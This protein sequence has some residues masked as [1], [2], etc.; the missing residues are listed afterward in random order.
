MKILTSRAIA[1]QCLIQAG[2][3]ATSQGGLFD[4]YETVD[5]ASIG[6]TL[7]EN[8]DQF[9]AGALQA[10]SKS[11]QTKLILWMAA[12][13]GGGMLAGKVVGKINIPKLGFGAPMT[14]PSTPSQPSVSASASASCAPSGKPD[15]NSPLCTDSDCQ[16]TN[17]KTCRVSPNQNCACLIMATA[18]DQW[19]DQTYMNLQQQ[20]IG[21]IDA[22]VFL[23]SGFS[24]STSMSM[25]SATSMP[26]TSGASRRTNT[27]SSSSGSAS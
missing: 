9:L 25:P 5:W 7:A 20:M 23:P 27:G 26:L 14:T 13:A 17:N 18:D 11:Q 12:A 2:A 3:K 15:V 22:G 16:G 4:S 8:A 1:L 6:L 24:G 21:S 19:Y 10:L